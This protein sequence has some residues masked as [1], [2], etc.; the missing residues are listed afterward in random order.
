MI[1][2]RRVYVVRIAGLRG[3]AWARSTSK[4]AALKACRAEYRRAHGGR[5]HEGARVEWS[6]GAR[7][8]AEL[9]P[10]ASGFDPHPVLG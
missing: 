2:K 9:S 3:V 7:S 6:E 8:G 5:L 1:P 10:T 4:R